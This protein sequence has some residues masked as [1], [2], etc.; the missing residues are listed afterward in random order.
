MYFY[1]FFTQF[2]RLQIAI[3]VAKTRLK[4]KNVLQGVFVKI[5][6]I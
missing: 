1:P 3:L 5:E 6:C 2:L 4:E